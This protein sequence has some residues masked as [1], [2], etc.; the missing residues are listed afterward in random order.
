MYSR[1][2]SHQ[3]LNAEV[4]FLSK[5]S[6]FFSLSREVLVL[7]SGAHWS[8][9]AAAMPSPTSRAIFSGVSIVAMCPSRS[10][11]APGGGLTATGL[12][13]L[14]GT[15]YMSSSLS[16]LSFSV[17]F[18][19]SGEGD[20]STNLVRGHLGGSPPAPPAATS[21]VPSLEAGR[22]TSLGRADCR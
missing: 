2:D 16:G 6:G 15:M 8:V 12:R 7:T 3:M 14:S 11:V 1:T 19:G 22:G 5:Y 18:P 9:Q 20:W 4:G 10:G 17:G 21:G 13:R